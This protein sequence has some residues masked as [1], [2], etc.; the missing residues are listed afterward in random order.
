[1]TLG[2]TWVVLGSPPKMNQF[3]YR[4]GKNWLY[5]VAFGRPWCFFLQGKEQNG[6]P[7]GQPAK[8]NRMNRVN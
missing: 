4:D 1:M 8:V 6:R 2:Y 7:T 5:I 3:L